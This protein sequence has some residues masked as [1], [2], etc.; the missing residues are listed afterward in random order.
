ML[1]T[2]IKRRQGVYFK[3][4]ATHN[5]LWCGC[6]VRSSIDTTRKLPESPSQQNNNK[7]ENHIKRLLKDRKGYVNSIEFLLYFTLIVFIIFG[8]IDY[9]LAEMQYS[10]VEEIKNFYLAQIKFQGTVTETI[11]NNIVAELEEIGFEDIQITAKDGLGNDLT[12]GHIALKNVNNPQQSIINLEILAKPKSKPFLIGR[13][14]G[15]TEQE[16][17]YFKVKGRDMS[18]RV[19]Y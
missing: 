9:Y 17:F 2:V 3:H 5:S 12:T 13:L 11:S 6:C 14:L 8:G 18:E 16:E 1:K 19:N 15:V 4:R 7:S 10:R